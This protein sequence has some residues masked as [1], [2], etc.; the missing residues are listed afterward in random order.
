MASV[1]AM[2]LWWTLIFV[3]LTSI[4]PVTSYT[5]LG[6]I[7]QEKKDDAES[8]NS[9]VTEKLR[10]LQKQVEL[11]IQSHEP[12]G[13]VS[14]AGTLWEASPLLADYITN[15]AC[16]LEAFQR[17]RIHDDDDGNVRL[18]PQP[19][20]VVELGSGVGLASW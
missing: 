6:G 13:R 17:M 16:P 20:T 5:I 4:P 9:F 2:I 10:H 8:E 11:R 18:Q 7:D 15:P 12:S 19:S 3:V 1:S 14:M